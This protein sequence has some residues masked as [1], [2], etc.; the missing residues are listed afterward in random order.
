MLES[1]NDTAVAIA[2]AVGGS[3]E[4]FADLMNQKAEELGC[5]DTHFV[6]PN[7]LDAN[8]HYTTANCVPPLTG[9]VFGSLFCLIDTVLKFAKPKSISFFVSIHLY[10]LCG[11]QPQATKNC[12]ASPQSSPMDLYKKGTGNIMPKSLKTYFSGTL[13]VLLPLKDNK[14][15]HHNCRTNPD[16][17]R[18][19]I[20]P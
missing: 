16:Y 3:V 19:G 15:D 11:G 10:P 18:I 13:P 9:S 4:G 12:S 7:G 17:Y 8:E 5:T 2:E 1:H 20:L 14:A 6:T